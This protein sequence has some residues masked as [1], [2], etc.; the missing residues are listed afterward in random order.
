MV[1][2]ILEH[3]QISLE[4]DQNAQYQ[5][6]SDLDLF[7]PSTLTSQQWEVAGIFVPSLKHLL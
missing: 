3:I 6:I 7:P 1:K 5:T 4:I 2:L